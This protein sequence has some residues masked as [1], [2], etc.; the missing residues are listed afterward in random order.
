[1]ITSTLHGNIDSEG[2]CVV[3]PEFSDDPGSWKYPGAGQDPDDGTQAPAH[4]SGD[5]TSGTWKRLGPDQL[6]YDPAPAEPETA[7]RK[8]FPVFSMV[9]FVCAGVT[10]VSC[11]WPLGVLGVVLGAIGHR[12]DERLGKW[13]ALA[14]VAATA[15]GLVVIFWIAPSLH[16]SHFRHHHR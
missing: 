12:R 8:T 13:A 14:S 16:L 10:L 4:P 1:M 9:G 15:V 3:G 11:I 2:G 5:E 7:A 6:P